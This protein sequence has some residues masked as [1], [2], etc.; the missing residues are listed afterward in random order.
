MPISTVAWMEQR[1]I[2]DWLAMKY[3]TPDFVSLHPG[4]HTE[5]DCRVAVA[6]RNAK[7]DS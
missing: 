1:V 7:K 6:L 3:I 5:K 4:Y 2:R